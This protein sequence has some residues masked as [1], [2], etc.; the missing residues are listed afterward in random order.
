[1][2]NVICFQ[3]V[4]TLK[5]CVGKNGHDN[6][7]TTWSYYAPE[8]KKLSTALKHLSKYKSREGGSGITHQIRATATNGYNS[9]L[10][11]SFI[12]YSQLEQ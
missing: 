5:S 12:P 1:M 6:L 10:F 2:K 8:Y 7:Y 4:W 9:G 3:I 11:E